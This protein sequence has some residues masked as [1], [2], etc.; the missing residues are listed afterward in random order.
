MNP[1]CS[2]VSYTSGQLTRMKM[3]NAWA[4]FEDL[5]RYADVIGAPCFVRKMETNRRGEGQAWRLVT[6]SAHCLMQNHLG[7][8]LPL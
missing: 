1:T 3:W 2:R 6:F 8:L 4:L 7:S 5:E